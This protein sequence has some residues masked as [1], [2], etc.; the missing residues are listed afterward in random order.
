MGSAAAAAP[1]ATAHLEGFEL[2]QLLQADVQDLIVHRLHM[3]G[4]RGNVWLLAP[5]P[6]G[7]IAHR[8]QLLE[9]VEL[10]GHWLRDAC[11][12]RHRLALLCSETAQEPE[13]CVPMPAR[14]QRLRSLNPAVACAAGPAVGAC[15]ASEPDQ[16]SAD[17]CQWGMLLSWKV[18]DTAIHAEHAGQLWSWTPT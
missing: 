8:S 18:I 17:A 14:S 5:L 13:L 10:H 7:P 3:C 16:S 12:A 11:R 15:P 9:E 6:P 4:V 1:A 2:L